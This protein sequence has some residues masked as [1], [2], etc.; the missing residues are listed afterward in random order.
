MKI[1]S[2]EIQVL[3]SILKYPVISDKS[4]GLLESNKYTFMVDRH[5]DKSV[6]KTA[7]NSLFD[8]T[9]LNVNTLNIPPKK[10]T[11][12]RFSGYKSKY[13]KAIITLKEG[14]TLDLFPDR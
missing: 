9:V 3:Q 1:K 6:I 13:K 7:I 10:R 11:V 4:T 14:D 2:Q 12:G 8:V 5:A